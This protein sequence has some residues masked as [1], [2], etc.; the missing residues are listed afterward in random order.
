MILIF[1]FC[2]TLDKEDL[3]K[4]L[5]LGCYKGDPLVLL[6]RLLFFLYQRDQNNLDIYLLYRAFLPFQ[7]LLSFH[8]RELQ[9]SG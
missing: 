9:N 7:L 1:F 4:A 8:A 5:T 6:Y 3:S 2:W